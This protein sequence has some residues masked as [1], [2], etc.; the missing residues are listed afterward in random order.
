MLADGIYPD[1]P[2]FMRTIPMP[3]GE[4]QKVFAKAQESIRKYVE[5]AC[6]R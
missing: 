6:P 2:I 1:W 5:R 3:V 4:K